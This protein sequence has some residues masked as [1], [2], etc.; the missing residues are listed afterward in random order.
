MLQTVGIYSSGFVVQTSARGIDE[1]R[2]DSLGIA[3]PSN[4]PSTTGVL[5]TAIYNHIIL[6]ICYW[7]VGQR[8]SDSHEYLLPQA[9]L[10]RPFS[11]S[12]ILL[13]DPQPVYPDA[14]GSVLPMRFKGPLT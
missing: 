10:Q 7:V 5:V 13:E 14:R 1:L 3:P 2:Y 8:T 6:S 11:V 12:K 9:Q 4:G